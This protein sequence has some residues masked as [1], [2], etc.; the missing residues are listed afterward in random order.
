MNLLEGF[1]LVRI[2]DILELN[3]FIYNVDSSNWPNLCKVTL[4]F[5]ITTLKTL[6]KLCS[7]SSGLTSNTGAK[8]LSFNINSVV[9][10][11]MS[12]CYTLFLFPSIFSISKSEEGPL[13]GP[14][15]STINPY[16]YQRF[17]FLK[18]VIHFCQEFIEILSLLEFGVVE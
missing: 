11:I 10:T 1:Q 17:V 4:E 8:S 15:L 7:T 3:A 14:N 12:S 16:L 18:D 9:I 5:L 2:S 6:T 13:Q